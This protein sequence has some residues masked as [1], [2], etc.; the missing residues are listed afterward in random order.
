MSQLY[1]MYGRARGLMAMAK[2]LK[3]EYPRPLNQTLMIGDHWH[4]LQPTRR[5]A[6]LPHQKST[7]TLTSIQMIEASSFLQ[8]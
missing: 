6:S 7:R 1:A 4:F 8:W 2:P 3:I 5:M